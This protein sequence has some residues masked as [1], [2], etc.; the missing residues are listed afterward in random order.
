MHSY[1]LYFH[2]LLKAQSLYLKACKLCVLSSYRRLLLG[3]VRAAARPPFLASWLPERGRQALNGRLCAVRALSQHSR[4]LSTPGAAPS[5]PHVEPERSWGREVLSPPL[6]KKDSYLLM[7]TFKKM[8]TD[9]LG[10]KTHVP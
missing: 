3:T 1:V 8:L 2:S 10:D 4:L 5:A 9:L 6:Q 7:E